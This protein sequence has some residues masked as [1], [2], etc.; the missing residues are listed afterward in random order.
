MAVPQAAAGAARC[1]A[2]TEPAFVRDKGPG[3]NN[4]LRQKV[5]VLYLANSALD[6][7][8]VGWSLYDGTATEAHTTGDSD[9]PPYETG[10]AALRDGWRVIQ[11]PILIPPYP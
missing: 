11:F 1:P 9:A 3:M 6:S 2:W 4:R 7:A 5:L 10:L 8:V